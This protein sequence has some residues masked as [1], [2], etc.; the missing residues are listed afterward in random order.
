[1]R[2]YVCELSVHFS[3]EF[4]VFILILC[5]S[6]YNVM[7]VFLKLFYLFIYFNNVGPIRVSLHHYTNTFWCATISISFQGFP[8]PPPKKNQKKPPK[9]AVTQQAIQQTA[10]EAPVSQFGNRSYAKGSRIAWTNREKK[11]HCNTLSEW[12]EILQ[13]QHSCTKRLKPAVSNAMKCRPLQRTATNLSCWSTL[14]LM[15]LMAWI[16]NCMQSIAQRF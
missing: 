5:L 11:T 4:M 2:N 8:A 9:N 12:H 16:R 13:L 10:Y 14:A 3:D 6:E 15:G 7:F 1:M